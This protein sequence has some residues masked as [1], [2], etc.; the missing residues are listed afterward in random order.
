[1]NNGYEYYYL[2][3]L[4]IPLE[5]YGLGRIKQLKIIDYLSK[6]VDIDNFYM[7]FVMNEIMIGQLE[8]SK[9]GYELKD[10][11]GS[12]TFLLTNCMNANKLEFINMLLSNLKVLY[13][14][15]NVKLSN[16]LTI[17]IED[18][19]EL[20]NDNFDMLCSVVLDL[21][22]I[23]KSKLKFDKPNKEV[24]PITARFEELRRKHKEKVGSKK[25]SID[26]T[27]IINIIIHSNEGNLNYNN[28]LNM[29]IYQ[30]KNTYETLS[31]KE[32]YETMIQYK[33]SQ[34]F[35]VKEDV[36]SWYTKKIVKSSSIN[37]GS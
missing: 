32:S 34:K 4:D 37:E 1:M 18:T 12:L 29:T 21:F 6:D 25:N 33:L 28:V 9:L 13:R 24:D 30:I 35:D 15:D 14:T 22:K 23:D 36:K 5:Q 19:I 31:I 2:F 27:D 11:L 16:N 3:G 26:L 10:T 8:D 20:S 7:P 17:L